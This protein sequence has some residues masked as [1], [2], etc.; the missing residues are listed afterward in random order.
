MNLTSPEDIKITL[1]L[2]AEPCNISIK[3]T[4]SHAGVDRNAHSCS[5]SLVVAQCS[6]EIVNVLTTLIKLLAVEGIHHVHRVPEHDDD[7]SVGVESP[8]LRRGRLGTQVA[9]ARFANALLRCGPLEVRKVC[10]KSYARFRAVKVRA[11]VVRLFRGGH[12]NV[13]VLPQ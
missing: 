11:E 5:P 10:A 13:G 12:E 6:L 7:P 4:L 8:D 9:G 3:Q 2:F 1:D